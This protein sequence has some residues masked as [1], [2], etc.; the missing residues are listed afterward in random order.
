[1]RTCKHIRQLLDGQALAELAI[2]LPLLILLAL[3]ATDFSRL[4]HHFQAVESAA[5][6]G[7]QYGCTSVSRAVDTNGIWQAAMGQAQ[8]IT[9]RHPVVSSSVASN[10]ISVTVTATFSTCIRWPGI[11]SSTTVSRSAQMRVLR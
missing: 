8:D 11:P 1:M 10:M 9:N 3:G 2:I 4:Y 6:A 7:A 5:A